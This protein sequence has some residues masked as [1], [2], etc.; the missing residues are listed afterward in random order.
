[1]AR[2]TKGESRLHAYTSTHSEDDLKSTWSSLNGFCEGAGARSSGL[3]LPNVRFF[4]K[5]HSEVAVKFQKAAKRRFKIIE[6]GV[7]K[8]KNKFLRNVHYIF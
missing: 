5:R 2:K 8:V 6:T 1:M 3:F 7:R 4:L